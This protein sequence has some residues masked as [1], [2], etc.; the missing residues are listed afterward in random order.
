MKKIMKPLMAGWLALSLAGC[1]TNTQTPAATTTPS[2]E[3]AVETDVLV[4]GAG[5]AGLAAAAGAAENGAQVLVLEA[6]SFTGG[7]TRI[8]GGHMAMLNEEMN[9]AMD[10]NDDQLDVYLTY[11]PEEFGEWGEALTTLQEQIRQ[12]QASAEPGRFDSVEMM[13]V[14]HYLAGRGKDL[15]GVEATQ[16]YTLVKTALDANWDIFEW[17]VSGGMTIQ[18]SYYKS[19]AGALH[20]NSPVDGGAGLI[21]ALQKLAEDAGAQIV[22]ETR[23]TELIQED[24]RIT[25]VK[26]TNKDGT[27]IVYKAKSGVIL[28]TGGFASNGELCAKVQRIGTGL[29]AENG[30]TNPATN[31]GDGILMAEAV[32]AQTRDMQFMSTLIQGYHGSSSIAQAGTVTAN[33]QLTVNA[34]AVRYGD[35]TQGSL[36]KLTNNQPKGVGF[37][38]GDQTMIDQM[39]EVKEGFVEDRQERGFMFVADTLEEAATMA[40]LDPQVLRATVDQYNSYVEAGEDPD[41]GR[42]EFNGKVETGPFVISKLEMHYHLTF[43]GLVIDTDAHVLAEAGQPISGLYA[44]GDVT[45]G[46]EGAAHQSGDC[47]SVVV[48]Y[49]KTAGVNAAQGK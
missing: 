9:A 7:A 13:L 45:S 37:Y 48:Y 36:T 31:I 22:F 17:L 8:S 23:A 30:S 15:D 25:G 11:T 28:A 5:G 35:E 16:D 29:C 34:D 3:T 42:K 12:Y 2:S 38:I 20:A 33:K 44:A 40:G 27:E 4:I 43:G 18:D 21:N 26:A 10:R 39:N 41:F 6:G 24:G 32:G 49:G 1:G 47:L 19:M 46:Y 14:D